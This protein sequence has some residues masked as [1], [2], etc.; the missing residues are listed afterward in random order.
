MAASV[1]ER[2]V[3]RPRARAL[4]PAEF[5]AAVRSLGTAKIRSEVRVEEVRPPQKLAP[6]THALALTVL[7]GDDEPADRA[8]GRCCTT[9]PA[10]RPGRAHAAGR[11][12]VGRRS[13]SEMASDPLLPEVGWSWLLESLEAAGAEYRAAGGTVTRTSS[14]RFGDLAGPRRTSD[15]ELRGSWTP[16]GQDDLAPH[17]RRLRR[18]ALHRRRAAA[19][20]GHRAADPALS[21]RTAL[22]PSPRRAAEVA[23]RRRRWPR[24]RSGRP[25][26]SAA[27]SGSRRVSVVPCAGRRWSRPASRRTAGPAPAAGRDR[28]GGRGRDAPRRGRSRGRRR[29]PGRPATPPRPA[30]AASASSTSACFTTLSSASWKNR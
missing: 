19:G 20:R 15:V 27:D 23:G 2:G 4:A 30:S 5:A 26:R 28:R 9:R 22:G 1:P 7:V 13:T 18:P 16:V 10:T 8:A 25:A 29:G 3:P 24:R 12:R 11:L 14:T 6:W 21:P 17:L